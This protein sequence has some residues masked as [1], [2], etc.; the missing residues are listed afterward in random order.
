MRIRRFRD[1][2]P[3]RIAVLSRSA[4][5]FLYDEGCTVRW[6]IRDGQWRHVTVKAETEGLQRPSHRR[7]L[8]KI[9]TWRTEDGTTTRVQYSK[10]YVAL[11]ILV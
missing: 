11:K 9:E 5:L 3:V 4:H 2:G 6:R 7:L 1:D 8:A 10:K